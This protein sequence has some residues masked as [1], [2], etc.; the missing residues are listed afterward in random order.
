MDSNTIERER[1]LEKLREEE[2]A[3]NLARLEKIE[4]DRDAAAA[5]AEAERAARHKAWW[6][7]AKLSRTKIF[8]PDSVQLSHVMHGT[9]EHRWRDADGHL[10]IGQ[11]TL[12]VEIDEAGRR[13][14]YGYPT[15]FDV[16]LRNDPTGAWREANPQL[17]AEYDARH[18]R[19]QPDLPQAYEERR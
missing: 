14:I 9:S 2:A 15:T 17:A 4:R 19:M 7:G 5:R 16:L 3:E 11:E 13:V 10:G 18:P 8:V 1:V 12:A 6:A